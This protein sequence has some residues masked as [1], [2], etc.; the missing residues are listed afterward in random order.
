MF[1][2][3]DV[4]GEDEALV[5]SLMKAA[6]PGDGDS[7][8]VKWNFEKFLVSPQGEV[9]ARWDTGTTPE[10]IRAALAEYF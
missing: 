1:A 9:V 7:S 6:Q 10:A 5:Y 2:K 3:I 4:N 8:D